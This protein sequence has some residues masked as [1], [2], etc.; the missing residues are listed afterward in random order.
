MESCNRRQ[1]T[2]C[3]MDHAVFYL[4]VVTVVLTSAGFVSAQPE[5]TAPLM[6]MHTFASGQS[7]AVVATVVLGNFAFTADANVVWGLNLEVAV[8]EQTPFQDTLTGVTQMWSWCVDPSKVDTCRLHVIAGPT[9][10]MY[11]LN[12]SAVWRAAEFSLSNGGVFDIISQP[13]PSFAL[14]PSPSYMFPVV[15]PYFGSSSG[16]IFVLGTNTS[17]IPNNLPQSTIYAFDVL[18]LSV[19]WSTDIDS[20]TSN[21]VTKSC[22]E[23]VWILTQN[24]SDT[25]GTP[26]TV[27]RKLDPET[28][29]LVADWA[30]N[31]T[32]SSTIQNIGVGGGQFMVLDASGRLTFAFTNGTTITSGYRIP[33]ECDRMPFSPMLLNSTWYAMCGTYVEMWDAVSITPLTPFVAPYGIHCGA[34]RTRSSEFVFGTDSASLYI[35]TDD[36][37]QSFTNMP[38][39]GVLSACTGIAFDATNDDVLYQSVNSYYGGLLLVISVSNRSVMSKAAASVSP[40]GPP[41]TDR[42]RRQLVVANVNGYVLQSYA[43]TPMNST[44]FSTSFWSRTTQTLQYAMNYNP[45][46][47]TIYYLGALALYSI[48]L[49]GTVSTLANFSQ[50]LPSA[51]PLTFVG[52]FL[53]FACNDNSFVYVFDTV[54]NEMSTLSGGFNIDP[55]AQPVV[56]PDSTKVVMFSTSDSVAAY[57]MDAANTSSYQVIAADSPRTI[58]GAAFMTTFVGTM[59]VINTGGTSICGF[60]VTSLSN[61]VYPVPLFNTTV[62][63]SNI[64]S[65]ISAPTAYQDSAAYFVAQ[66]QYRSIAVFS[67]DAHGEVR[68]VGLLPSQA[69]TTPKLLVIQNSGPIPLMYMFG[70]YNVETYTL[71]GFKPVFSYQSP[72]VIIATSSPLQTPTFL[73][74]GLICFYTTFAFTVLN[75]SG[76]FVWSYRSTGAMPPVTDGVNIFF[77]D[78]QYVIGANAQSGAVSSL[79]SYGLGTLQGQVTLNTGTAVVIRKKDAETNRNTT[80][81]VGATNAC[82]VFANE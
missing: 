23:Y 55:T 64:T 6:R 30:Y 52:S 66:V 29:T 43:F 11:S 49:N 8:N 28:G 27:V 39:V 3:R 71:D 54:T 65:V 37:V 1:I 73:E 12:E 74:G 35:A 15:V 20:D 4:S 46:T 42:Q 16:A 80:L 18:N 7:P 77:S 25:N 58:N 62:T 22:G 69:T 48:S 14:S 32:L 19:V 10:V 50:F 68:E 51:T 47:E 61:A 2:I 45:T 63:N 33:K 56:L 72:N 40:F 36:G 21:F 60:N 9:V 53:V 26:Y 76:E 79:S 34:L 13:S 57:V 24:Q 78:G 82:I 17:V 67:V 38:D 31:T 44:S 75:A 70:E 41:A 59:L 81:V 5:I